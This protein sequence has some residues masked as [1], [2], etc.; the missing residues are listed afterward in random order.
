MPDRIDTTIA[1]MRLSL[2]KAIRAR[3]GWQLAAAA[4]ILVWIGLLLDRWIEPTPQERMTTLLGILI[5]GLLWWLVRCLPLMIYRPKEQELVGVIAKARPELADGLVASTQVASEVVDNPRTSQEKQAF[6]LHETNRQRINLALEDFEPTSAFRNPKSSFVARV[7]ML[8]WASALLF[9]LVFPSQASLYLKRIALSPEPWP[10]SVRLVPE[11]FIYQENN[12]IWTKHFPR[13]T[14]VELL[15]WADLL[16]EVSAP[17]TVRVKSLQFFERKLADSMLRVGELSFRPADEPSQEFAQQKSQE[18]K[19]QK[20]RLRLEELHQSLSLRLR[21]GGDQVVVQL[22]ASDRP[23]VL[24]ARL[25]VTLPAYLGQEKEEIEVSQLRALP[26]GS[27]LEILAS[28]NKP[29]SNAT[30]KWLAEE[31]E[32]PNLMIASNDFTMNPQEIRFNSNALTANGSLSIELT[33]THRIKSLPAYNLPIEILTDEPPTISTRFEGI[34]NLITSNAILPTVITAKDDHRIVE[35]FV[36]LENIDTEKEQSLYRKEIA[37]TKE[38][39]KS[40]ATTE[41]LDLESIS[42]NDDEEK[43]SA[44]AVG[45]QLR[46]YATAR[47]AYD[48]SDRSPSQSEPRL[49]QVVSHEELMNHLNERERE[50]RK[51]LEGVLA[52]AR[53][54]A[55]SVERSIE[56]SVERSVANDDSSNSAGEWSLEVNKIARDIQSVLS[57]TNDIK[58]EVIHNRLEQP[59]MVD[60]LTDSVILPLQELLN[61]ELAS[62]TQQLNRSLQTTDSI[63]NIPALAAQTNKTARVIETVIE[64]MQASESYNEVVSTLRRILRE[65]KQL[66]KQTEKEQREEALRALLD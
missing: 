30:A 27:A 14:S 37:L 51:T 48:L 6:E 31:E 57:R 40:I 23:K 18:K 41:S 4:G 17:E 2:A 36:L 59:A 9:G 10:R 16:E 62:I 5:V 26:E 7:A 64:A 33:D 49:L 19:S 39:A 24:S 56:Q 53:R 22:I 65:Q 32:A 43:K 34:G 12:D 54:I 35:A 21:G 60:R 46:L 63:E 50:L 11:G 47:D 58:R 3:I 13:G 38:G 8:A 66:N 52:D 15:V 45:D 25:T 44:I 42:R 61:E 20:Y 29:L 55:Y 1:Q 28:V